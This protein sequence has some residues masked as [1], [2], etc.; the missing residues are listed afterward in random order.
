[1]LLYFAI[2]PTVA[3]STWTQ[4]SNRDFDNGTLVNLSI[5]GGGSEAVLQINLS[6]LHNWV[7]RSPTNTPGPSPLNNVDPIYGDDKLLLYGRA[8]NWT[9]QIMETW[10]Y[11][12]SDD[13]WTDRTPSSAPPSYPSA[14]YSQPLASIYGDDKAITF[15]GGAFTSG[16]VYND[17]WEYDLSEDIWTDKTQSYSP[18]ARQNHEMS[19]TY[20]DGKVVLFGGTYPIFV[21]PMVVYCKDTWVY[22]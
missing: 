8:L 15:G 6:D 19:Y 12:F 14:L 9:L 18:P 2:Q 16:L 4:T 22:D 11:D 17:T 10:V 7:G 13:T 5:E 1:M 3:G 21:M 20:C